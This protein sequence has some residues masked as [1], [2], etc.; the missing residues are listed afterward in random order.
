MSLDMTT[1]LLATSKK[2]SEEAAREYAAAAAESAD[3]AAESA[4]AVQELA[5]TIENIVPRVEAVEDKTSVLFNK[6]FG[7]EIKTWA[8]VQAIVRAGAASQ[9]F[10]I[11]DQLVAEKLGTISASKGDSTGI[12]AVTVDSAAFLEKIGETKAGVY[13]FTYDG[14][15]RDDSGATVDLT[16]YGIAVTGTPAVGDT[17]IVTETTTEFTFDI[18]GIDHDTPTDTDYEHSMTIQMH[19][20]WPSAMVFDAREAFFFAEEGLAAGTYHITI[21]DSAWYTSDNGKVYQFTLENAVP[22][23]GQLVFTNS[24][25]ATFANSKINVFA[26]SADTTASETPTLTL[27]SEGT[28]LGAVNNTGNMNH[29][30]RALLGNNNWGDSA[31]RQWLNT[32]EAANS[33]W[34]AQNKFDRPAN[35]GSDG[36]LRNFDAAFLAVLGNVNKKTQLSVADGYGMEESTEKVFLLS[37]DELYFGPE[38]STDGTEGSVYAYYGPGHSDLSAPGT[39]ADTNKVKYRG[40]SAAYWWMRSPNAGNGYYVRFVYTDGSLNYYN[41]CYNYG[42]APACAIV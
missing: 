37:R 30:H 33:W 8:D 34:T 32:D 1:F 26:S 4:A 3:A 5:E 18:I 35:A 22:E 16:Q 27:G 29:M 42:V 28:D 2:S 19:D 38:R 23:G 10:S 13:N 21:Q 24:Y 7:G 17:V 9:F 39:G 40:G 11:G 36:F 25:N 14:R 12:T 15:W 41:A 20:Q 6:I 31:I